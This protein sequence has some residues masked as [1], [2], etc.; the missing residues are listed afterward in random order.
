MQISPQA[1]T[2]KALTWELSS[3]QPQSPPNINRNGLLGLKHRFKLA[4][5]AIYIKLDI[6]IIV[7][8]GGK[9]PSCVCRAADSGR[10]KIATAVLVF[11]WLLRGL[12]NAV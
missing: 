4:L 2:R 10:N 5:G 9:C 11:S 12:G 8:G 3:A 1:N 6:I 7:L